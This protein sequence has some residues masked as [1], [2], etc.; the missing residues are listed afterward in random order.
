MRP[1]HIVLLAVLAALW[2]V[3]YA[4]QLFTKAEFLWRAPD[5]GGVAVNWLTNVDAW[6]LIH[7]MEPLI[8]GLSLAVILSGWVVPDIWPFIK[9]Q[10]FK[11]SVG[12]FSANFRAR[13]AAD[14]RQEFRLGIEKAYTK[15]FRAQYGS[16]RPDGALVTLVDLVGFPPDFPPPAHEPLS[17]YMASADWPSTESQELG[18]FLFELYRPV[19]DANEAG[20]LPTSDLQAFIKARNVA[21]KF[22]DDCAR[23]ILEGRLTPGHVRRRLDA[24]AR[25]IKLLALSE[26]VLAE[27]IPWDIGGGKTSLFHLA[28]E[29]S[30]LKRVRSQRWWAFIRPRAEHHPIQGRPNTP[31]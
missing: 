6:L 2:I 17:G 5:V 7:D 3:N 19:S 24:N 8:V 28:K 29:G 18:Q 27:L 23:E 26:L 12:T 9:R 20:L 22:W 10:I 14:A 21:S 1:R 15:Y 13:D 30:A 11:G 31:A 16:E 25:D 4:E